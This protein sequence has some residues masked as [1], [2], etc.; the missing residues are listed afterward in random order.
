MARSELRETLDDIDDKFNVPKQIGA[1]K[2]RAQESWQENPIPWIIGSV[3]AV[4]VIGGLI[5]WS[6]LNDE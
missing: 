2:L 6:L 5:A 1:A 4:I 3:A